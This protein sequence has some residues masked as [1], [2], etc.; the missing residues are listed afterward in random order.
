MIISLSYSWEMRGD[1]SRPET[2]RETHPGAGGSQRLKKSWPCECQWEFCFW[3]QWNQHFSNVP[4]KSCE[5]SKNHSVLQWCSQSMLLSFTT[6]PL[7][8]VLV[9]LFWQLEAKMPSLVQLWAQEQISRLTHPTS[10]HP[11]NCQCM[12]CK[13]DLWNMSFCCPFF[14][15]RVLEKMFCTL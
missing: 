4:W 10:K 8:Q 5:C 9:Q 12:V 13:I 1:F 2:Q 6:F 11:L 15:R 14:L 7:A 3:Y